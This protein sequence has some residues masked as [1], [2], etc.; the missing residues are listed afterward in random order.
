MLDQ[1]Q[2]EGQLPGGPRVRAHQGRGRARPAVDGDAQDG[3]GLTEEPPHQPGQGQLQL[4]RSVRPGQVRVRRDQARAEGPPVHGQAPGEQEPGDLLEAD[5]GGQL[6]SGCEGLH[7]GFELGPV[8]DDQGPVPGELEQPG[9]RLPGVLRAFQIRAADPEL[10]PHATR[11]ALPVPARRGPLGRSAE[12][13]REG[14]Q[15]PPVAVLGARPE[16]LDAEQTVAPGVRARGPEDRQGEAS[17][18]LPGEPR[19][20][21][22]RGGGVLPLDHGAQRVPRASGRTA[23]SARAPVPG[24]PAFRDPSGTLVVSHFC[25][26]AC[27]DSV[28]RLASPPA[29]GVQ[30]LNR[31]GRGACGVGGGTGC[32]LRRRLDTGSGAPINTAPQPVPR[33][34]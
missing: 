16:G 3:F 29:F 26:M 19:L 21:R 2:A 11:G 30:S 7:P 15:L 10:A 9:D 5:R 32:P 22:A 28:A 23:R 13:A 6:R 31:C 27:V 8:G 4:A 17:E 12:R 18:G 1:A 24:G 33:A 34:D 14:V 20:H 25:E